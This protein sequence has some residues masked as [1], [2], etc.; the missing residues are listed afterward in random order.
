MEGAT[1]SAGGVWRVN[2]ATVATN[3]SFSH[4]SMYLSSYCISKAFS[5]VPVKS[6]RTSVQPVTY[7]LPLHLTTMGPP[8][9]PMYVPAR[10]FVE[11]I[12]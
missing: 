1:R 6:L 12:T 7:N 9:Q 5:R 10:L 3:C 11:L 2:K 4:Q 8:V